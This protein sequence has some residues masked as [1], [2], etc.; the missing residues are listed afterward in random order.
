MEGH[1]VT[2]NPW[3]ILII[4]M[5]IVYGVLCALWA[6]MI[7]IKKLDP[8]QK[9]TPSVGAS[10]P[11]PTAPAAQKPMVPAVATQDNKEEIVAAISAAIVAMGYSSSQIASVRPV[12]SKQW[13]LEGRLS[14]RM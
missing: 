6:I 4:N 5:T 14:G 8:T 13:T 11:A 12:V 1:V 3:L 10:A 9:R 2:T 7:V